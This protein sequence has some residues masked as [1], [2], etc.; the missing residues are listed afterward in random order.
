MTTTATA[1]DL[2]KVA[3]HLVE[4]GRTWSHPALASAE[5]TRQRLHWAAED[6]LDLLD[7]NSLLGLLELTHPFKPAEVIGGDLRRLFINGWSKGDAGID[8]QHFLAAMYELIHNHSGQTGPTP[9]AMGAF[10]TGFCRMLA[11]GHNGRGF[12]L[13]LVDVDEHD[14]VVRR[15]DDLTPALPQAFATAWTRW[16]QQPGQYT[17]AAAT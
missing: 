8:Q 17:A 1:T 2:D 15:G 4:L 5:Q 16:L 6:L 10:L 3:S 7:G 11:A 13:T 9:A 12:Q 14:Q